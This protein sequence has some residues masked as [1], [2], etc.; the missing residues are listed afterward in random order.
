MFLQQD[1]LSLQVK[2]LLSTAPPPPNP[3]DVQCP[4]ASKKSQG[5]S[6]KSKVAYTIKN[7]APFAIDLYWVN[8]VGKEMQPGGSTVRWRYQML[9]GG[10]IEYQSFPGHVFRAR[11]QGSGILLFEYRLGQ[12]SAQASTVSTCIEAAEYLSAS[13]KQPTPPDNKTMALDLPPE[14]P[15]LVL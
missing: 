4:E 5:G 1:Y 12:H 6:T 10:A 9:A 3:D 15:S 2:A 13:Q 8:S 14:A 11:Q 7:T